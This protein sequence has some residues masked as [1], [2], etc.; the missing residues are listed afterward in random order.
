MGEVVEKAQGVQGAVSETR[1][2]PEK[3]RAPGE[4]VSDTPGPD[5]GA[6]I[7][8]ADTPESQDLP[9][10]IGDLARLP[11]NTIISLDYLAK[12]V[13]KVC[14]KTIRRSIRRGEIPPPVALPGRAKASWTVGVLLSHIQ[15]RLERAARE[16]ERLERKVE[17][18]AP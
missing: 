2:G 10:V 1:P 4:R 6:E 14:P 13:F 15:A 9:G 3:T 11:G 17:A 16:R 12:V 8:G 18:L 5:A 7:G